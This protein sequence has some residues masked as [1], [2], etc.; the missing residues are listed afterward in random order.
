M[1]IAATSDVHSPRYFDLLV[2]S[3]D[4]INVKVDIVLLAGDMIRR[5]DVKEY[6]KIY[7]IFFGKINC[8]II[9]CF[10]NEERGLETRI[11]VENQ[12]PDI[13]FLD[14]ETMTVEIND[15]KV[16][17]VGTLG[18]LDR[19]TFWQR[20]NIPNIYEIYK[21]RIYTVEGLLTT[22]KTDIKI[23]L[24]HYPPTYKIMEGE[25]PKAYGEL[26]SK[27]FER[28]LTEQEPDIVITGHS[29]RGKKMAWIETIP[30]FNVAMPLHKEIVI[31]DTEKDLKPGLEKF[32][33]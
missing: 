10:G 7:N 6:Q 15:K 5:R 12:V 31:I 33:G 20:N 3:I 9:A 2:K 21:N 16:G 8:P 11:L 28:V 22:L 4:D 19:P 24:I 26:G 18:S 27:N 17:I 29:H 14:D 1:I 25:D 30:I 32:I 23:L 13:N